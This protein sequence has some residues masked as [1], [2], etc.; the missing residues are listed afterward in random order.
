M[1]HITAYYFSTEVT[2]ILRQL[3]D[4]FNQ[5]CNKVLLHLDYGGQNVITFFNYKFPIWRKSCES[6]VPIYRDDYTCRCLHALSLLSSSFPNSRFIQY[7]ESF[8]RPF[9]WFFRCSSTIM[10]RYIFQSDKCIIIIYNSQFPRTHST[11]NM[12][13]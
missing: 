8:S 10:F 12:T 3:L 7:F 5:L 4:M 1:Q 9:H 2:I 6:M 11:G 13:I